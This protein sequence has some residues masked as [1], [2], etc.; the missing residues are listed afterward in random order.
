VRLRTAF[1]APCNLLHFYF[2]PLGKAIS[3]EWPS[4]LEGA[5]IKVVEVARA[6]CRRPPGPIFHAYFWSDSCPAVRAALKITVVLQRADIPAPSIQAIAII[7]IA[8]F[9]SKKLA[10]VTGCPQPSRKFSA[11]IFPERF[12]ARS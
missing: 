5:L 8:Y 10:A 3:K 11:A 2:S 6:S 12:D 1:E 4:L 7:T 9:G